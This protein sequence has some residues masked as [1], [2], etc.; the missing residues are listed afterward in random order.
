MTTLHFSASACVL[1]SRCRYSNL[2]LENRYDY[3][4]YSADPPG[5]CA[6]VIAQ[7]VMAEGDD[8]E[9]S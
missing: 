6:D 9:S 2:S 1:C 7:Y 8:S 4:T 5:I 3:T